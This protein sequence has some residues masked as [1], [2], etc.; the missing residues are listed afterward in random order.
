MTSPAARKTPLP[1][2]MPVSIKK[3]KP[4]DALSS[5]LAGSGHA[6]NGSSIPRKDSIGWG[7]DDFLGMISHTPPAFSPGSLT[8]PMTKRN[9]S[10]SISSRLL[11]A[12]DLE[13][14]GVIDRYQKGVLK[15]LIISGDEALQK[16]LEKFDAGDSSTL[17]AMLDSGALNRK[18]SIDLLDDLDL[19]FLNV[20]SLGDTPKD[21]QYSSS[22]RS[23]SL[24]EWDELGFDSAFADVSSR[25]DILDGDFYSSSLGTSLPN[26]LP[27]M[28]LGITPPATFSFAED[29]L[30]NQVKAEPGVKS[31]G[32]A[33][34]E[35]PATGAGASP[36]TS[37][38]TSRPIGIPGASPGPAAGGAS[39]TFGAAAMDKDKAGLKQ[40]FVGAYSPDSRRKRI[41]KFLDKRQK[42]VWRKEVKYDVRKNFADSR[43]RVKGRFVK[44]E[45]EQLLRELLSFT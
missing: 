21:E 23:Q 44:K 28:G 14:R 37:S 16:A 41:E 8:M 9:R 19:G 43:L 22:T 33:G 36:T 15:D 27:S 26:S 39:R 5:M 3:E 30:E 4:H 29:F 45:D 20:G 38:A 40:S 6:G 32:K 31:E 2:T 13:E 35:S 12:S 7:A 42:R 17:E 18:S 10:G 24:D 1:P 25:D 34:Q 11:S